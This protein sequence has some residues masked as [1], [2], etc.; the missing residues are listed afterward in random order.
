MIAWDKV[1]SRITSMPKDL[2][3][4]HVVSVDI[5]AAMPAAMRLGLRLPLKKLAEQRRELT[6]AA[7]GTIAWKSLLDSAPLRSDHPRPSATDIAL[8]QYT[9][10]TTGQPKGAMLSHRNLESNALMGQHWL[11]SS[12]DEVVYGVLPLFHAFGLTLGLTFAMSLGAKLVLFPTV[13]ADLILKAMKK[14]MPTVL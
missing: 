8:L 5:T 3:V 4:E 10:G 12:S 9:S 14:S 2:A 7:P 11:D 1:A 13:R 6:A